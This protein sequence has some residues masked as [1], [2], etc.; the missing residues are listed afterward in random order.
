MSDYDVET[1]QNVKNKYFLFKLLLEE[2]L[3]KYRIEILM[4]SSYI[5]S[6]EAYMKVLIKVKIFLFLDIEDKA[7][8]YRG[9]YSFRMG[10]Y[11]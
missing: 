1:R 2:E 10:T 7:Y 9:F 8:I 3:I 5:R 11:S 4:F 6:R